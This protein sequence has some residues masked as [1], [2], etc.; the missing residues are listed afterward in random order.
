LKLWDK[1]PLVLDV[2]HPHHAEQDRLPHTLV[3]MNERVMLIA[4]QDQVRRVIRAT[5]RS[6][7]NMMYLL[8]TLAAE[9]AQL[10]VSDTDVVTYVLRERRFPRS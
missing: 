10:P 2:P 7:L 3:G 1:H 8:S 4:Q 9:A 5:A 6:V